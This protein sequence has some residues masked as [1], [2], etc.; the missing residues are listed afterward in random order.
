MVKEYTR[1]NVKD[2][3]GDGDYWII[4]YYYECFWDYDDNFISFSLV[5]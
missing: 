3:K 4:K 2:R 1:C 5:T